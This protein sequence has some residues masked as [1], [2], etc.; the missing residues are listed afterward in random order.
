MTA[1]YITDTRTGQRVRMPLI[2]GIDPG[3]EKGYALIDPEQPVIRRSVTTPR[4]LFLATDIL[5]VRACL[6]GNVR[7]LWV[8]VEYQYGN[9]VGAGEISA[10][11]IIRLA[12]RA[13]FMLREAATLPCCVDKF[14]SPPSSWKDEV[15]THGK[16]IRKD[17]FCNKLKARLTPEELALFEPI[18]DRNTDDVLDAIGIAWALALVMGD[19][20]RVGGW[21]V[22]D[23]HILP[24][25]K[26]P[27]R[28]VNEKRMLANNPGL[29]KMLAMREAQN[30]KKAESNE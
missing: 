6:Y 1:Q 7:P 10:D 29:Q 24:L 9:R 14:A 17:V 3:A 19:P 13:G 28:K 21:R 4:V 27:N 11:S 23:S 30:S 22:T 26:K 12:F 25:E 2:L 8:I 16:G 15:F 20:K 5:D 18:A